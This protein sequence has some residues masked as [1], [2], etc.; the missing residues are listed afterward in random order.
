MLPIDAAVA[1]N[2]NAKFVYIGRPG[3]LVRLH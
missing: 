1:D 3:L 2:D